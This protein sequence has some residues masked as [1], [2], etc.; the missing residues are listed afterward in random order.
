MAKMDLE[1]VVEEISNRLCRFLSVTKKNVVGKK[2]NFFIEPKFCKINV[3]DIIK[4]TGTGKPWRGDIKVVTAHGEQYWIESV[5]HP[6]FDSKFNLI[7]YTNIIQDITD[8]KAVEVLSITDAL[9]KIHNRRHYDDVIER[10][11][12]L[13]QRND[14]SLVFAMIDID[15]FKEFNDHYGHAAGDR[16]LVKVAAVLKKSMN[17]PNDYVFRLGGE[18]FGLLF[19]DIDI[20]KAEALLE[21]IRANIEGLRIKHIASDVNEFLTISIGAFVD[22]KNTLSSNDIYTNADKLLYK[23]KDSRNTV[24]IR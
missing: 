16:A 8:K 3:D 9:T 2:S 20:D 10:E 14:V 23:A 6:N 5:V 21:N 13:A 1:G 11:I 19:S 22:T 12:K 15:F 7:G 4:M 24:V 18:E 17:R